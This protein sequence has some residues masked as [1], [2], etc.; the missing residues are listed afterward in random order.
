MT[1]TTEGPIEE[2]AMYI[3]NAVTKWTAWTGDVT[4]AGN[5]IDVDFDYVEA[6][7]KDA[8]GSPLGI[9]YKTGGA[10]G[11]LIATLTLTYDVDGDFLTLTKI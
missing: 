9:I 1:P 5:L 7:S 8:F 3:W 11:T 2:T 6:T 4:I 10:V